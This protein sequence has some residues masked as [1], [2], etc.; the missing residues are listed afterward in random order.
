ML[1][2]ITIPVDFATSMVAYVGTLFTDLTPVIVILVGLPLGFW[3]VGKVIG[4]IRGG[5]RS[6][7]Y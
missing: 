7:R 6:R 2:I 5:F 4:L 3:A 1:S